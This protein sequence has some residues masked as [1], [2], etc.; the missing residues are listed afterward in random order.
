MFNVQELST[1]VKHKINLVHVIFSDGAF[2]NVQ[3]MQKK[4]YGGRVIGTDLENPD[5]VKLADAFGALGLRAHNA[6]E[7]K[8]AIQQGFDADRPTLIDVP[9][10]EMPAPWALYFLPKNRGK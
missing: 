3:R 6:D 8:T 1:A 7:L 5:F 10:G 9:V 4:D 2:G